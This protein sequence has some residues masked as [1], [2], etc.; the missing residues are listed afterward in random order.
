MSI[1]TTVTH[2]TQH[3][4][5]GAWSELDADRTIAMHS[6]VFDTPDRLLEE[7]KD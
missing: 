1:V 5:G 7:S 2:S 4:Q 6:I 3:A